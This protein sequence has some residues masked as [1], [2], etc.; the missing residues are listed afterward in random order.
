M[1]T[2]IEKSPP[3]SNAATSPKVKPAA[4]FLTSAV[5]DTSPE[6]GYTAKRFGDDAVAL[7]PVHQ[8]DSKMP[9]TLMFHAAN[10][11][12]V[13]YS[14]AVALYN[15]LKSSG[16]TCELVTVPIGGHGFSGD[17]PKWKQKERSSLNELF[18]REK[19]LPAVR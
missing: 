19:L 11:D 17:H 12:L 15:K 4:L 3:G 16:N 14:T 13:H 6:T 10:D 7:S 2:A 5:T 1:W 18:D 8:L 9:P